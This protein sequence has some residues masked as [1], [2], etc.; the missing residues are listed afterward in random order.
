[1]SSILNIN[2]DDRAVYDMLANARGA[3]AARETINKVSAAAVADRLRT[4]FLTRNARSSRSNYWSKAAEA[5]TH[6]AD[7]SSGWVR[8]RHPGVAWHRWGG[9]ISAKPGK[10]M[11]IPLRDVVRGIQP[12]EK[13]PDRQSAFVY[14]RHGKAFLAARENGALRIYYLLVKSVSKGPNADVL[15]SEAQLKV[16]AAL[17]VRALL[18]VHLSRRFPGSRS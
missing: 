14:R 15:P 18:Y 16:A 7:A 17:A 9:T 6:G 3:L 12:S 13:W 4:H 11:A 8:T 10:A 1:M 5:T 2:V